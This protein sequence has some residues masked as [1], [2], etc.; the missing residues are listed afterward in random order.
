MFNSVQAIEFEESKNGE[1]TCRVKVGGKWK[2]IYSKYRPQ[3]S[4][5]VPEV[6]D[7][8]PHVLLGLGLGYEVLAL[9]ENRTAPLYVVE[10]HSSFIEFLKSVPYF[11]GAFN[12]DKLRIINGEE[13]QKMTERFDSSSF[14]QSKTTSYDA[15]Y[16]A[17]V[18][19]FLS[20]K[21][22]PSLKNRILVLNH[23]TIANDCIDAFRNLGYDVKS[24]DISSADELAIQAAKEAPDYLF[25]INPHLDVLKASKL[26][27]IPYIFWN[28]DTPH[29]QLYYQEMC[30]ANVFAFIY[31]AVIAK[32]LKE[33]GYRNAH[34]LPVAAPLERFDRIIVSDEER[35]F[36]HAE[37]NFIGTL[38][39]ENEYNQFDFDQRAQA[40]LRAAFAAIF[41]AQEQEESYLIPKLVND[42]IVEKFE[43]QIGR[44]SPEA[45][46]SKKEKLAFFLAR[47][48]NENHRRML[49]KTLAE[50]FKLKLYG[51]EAWVKI[52]GKQTQ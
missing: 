36:Y 51:G 35:E 23:V 5:K 32:D 9:L 46:L 25:S 33:K 18:I 42:L 38:G 40:D 29:Y 14:L 34:Y 50:N 6:I 11:Q 15:H 19:R 48:F 49:A 28:V 24:L 20:E 44:M 1:Y 17:D 3:S 8:K 45:L 7:Q 43:H 39:E 10:K 4:I 52:K 21:S 41:D 37:V 2:Y 22:K 30:D 27:N 47:K 13:Y 26:L 31:D 12:D 16:Y